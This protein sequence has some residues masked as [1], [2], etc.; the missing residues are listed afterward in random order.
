MRPRIWLV[1]VG[2]SKPLVCSLAKREGWPGYF[3]AGWERDFFND[4]H[5]RKPELRD[6][7]N[8]V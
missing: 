6:P 5:P 4:V 7:D 2:G 1:G 3:A 8:I